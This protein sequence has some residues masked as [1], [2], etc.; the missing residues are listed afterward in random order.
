MFLYDSFAL[1]MHMILRWTSVNSPHHPHLVFLGCWPHCEKPYRKWVGTICYPIWAK[2]LFFLCLFW[3]FL[4]A[5]IERVIRPILLF[6]LWKKLLLR[7]YDRTVSWFP[8]SFPRFRQTD[9]ASESL[10]PA[11]QSWLLLWPAGTSS[12]CHWPLGAPGPLSVK[13]KI[14]ILKLLWV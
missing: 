4:E 3:L 9:S 13:W 5:R 8:L 2:A 11:F 14:I 10:E 7:T 12:I 6:F 1:K